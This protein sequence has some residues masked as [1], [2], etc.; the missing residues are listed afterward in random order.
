MSNIVLI[1]QDI[2]L[3]LYSQAGTIVIIDWPT[4]MSY[5]ISLKIDESFF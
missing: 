4:S 3:N 5:I 1:N 2:C